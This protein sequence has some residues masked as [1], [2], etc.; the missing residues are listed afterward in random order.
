M[1]VPMKTSSF[2]VA[3]V[4]AVSPSLA[5]ASCGGHAKSDDVV[6][7]CAEGTTYD[8]ETERCVPQTTS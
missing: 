4:V 1:E 5:F 7:S 8:V 3:L 6:M 2:L